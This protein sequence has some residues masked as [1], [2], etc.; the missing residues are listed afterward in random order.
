MCT[1]HH[2]RKFLETYENPDHLRFEKALRHWE[3]FQ[4]RAFENYFNAYMKGTAPTNARS[5]RDIPRRRAFAENLESYSK[6]MAPTDAQLAY[7]RSTGSLCSAM[8]RKSIRTTFTTPVR[9]RYGGEV[10][11]N[12]SG[13]TRKRLA[14]FIRDLAE[15]CA[16]EKLDFVRSLFFNGP[17]STLQNVSE[18]DLRVKTDIF[19]FYPNPKIERVRCLQ[20][21]VEQGLNP[22]PSSVSH[23]AMELKWAAATPL[24][25]E[26]N[27]PLT[28][29]S[30]LTQY[31]FLYAVSQGMIELV[32]KLLEHGILDTSSEM[33]DA[34]FIRGFHR[35]HVYS[36]AI[37][38]DANEEFGPCALI[39]ALAWRQYQAASLLLEHGVESQGGVHYLA[40]SKS[41]MQHLQ[42]ETRLRCLR[43]R[44]NDEIDE[45]PIP[46]YLRLLQ[47]RLLGPATGLACI[48]SSSCFVL[49]DGLS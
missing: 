35:R 31:V 22:S 49:N 19:W 34:R 45:M 10:K 9:F 18:D 2:P 44:Q 5:H 27:A 16:N 4:R 6:G 23:L 33:P 8:S 3:G 28:V 39:L 46:G 40:T 20:F 29:Q 15:A 13:V 41:A 11:S 36:D 32:S 14:D 26:K 43:G 1:G 38:A 47:I 24:L 30:R 42:D 17:L 12:S 7:R 37:I 48:T 25:F 21:M